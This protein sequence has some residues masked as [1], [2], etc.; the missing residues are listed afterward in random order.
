M[1]WELDVPDAYWGAPHLRSDTYTRAVLLDLVDEPGGYV[2]RVGPYSVE[3]SSGG[4]TCRVEHEAFD[5][6]R[7]EVAGGVEYGQRGLCCRLV[8]SDEPAELESDNEE[9]ADEERREQCKADA[10][11]R[12]ARR[13]SVGAIAQAARRAA[14]ARNVINSSDSSGEDDE[15][16]AIRKRA[17]TQSR[18]QGA[19]AV[20]KTT[21]MWPAAV[22]RLEQGAGDGNDEGDTDV[23]M[24][25]QAGSGS[26]A[27]TLI[28]AAPE[29]EQ[30]ERASDACVALVTQ[31]RDEAQH[32]LAWHVVREGVGHID[33]AT[34]PSWARRRGA[35]S[36]TRC[37]NSPP[38]TSTGSR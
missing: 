3:R 2:F 33:V 31:L 12:A 17:T 6:S 9:V 19:S 21:Y 22:R 35:H 10:M 34:S 5:L 20:R 37:G 27:I 7:E 23:E 32:V 38:T 18:K 13:D 25:E 30:S 29:P 24:G 28:A 26:E 8:P 36:S 15:T 16:N 11:A 4:R 14:R 1:G